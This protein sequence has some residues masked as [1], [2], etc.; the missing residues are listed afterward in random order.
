MSQANAENWSHFARQHL[1]Q[2]LNHLLAL[3]RIT[4]TVA[5]EKAVVM[6]R[7]GKVVRVW[8]YNHI[9]TTRREAP[10]LIEL[11]ANIHGHN[12]QCL[13]ILVAHFSSRIC[14]IVFHR[15][16][17]DFSHQVARVRVGPLNLRKVVHDCL[18][19]DC[20]ATCELAKHNL[21][22][23]RAL[24][25]NQFREHARVNTVQR[26]NVVLDQPLGQ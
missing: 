24:V 3:L 16:C 21:A 23:S 26:R 10:D 17:R 8:N 13:T 15:L 19:S 4:G 11:H 6:G 22:K 12:S 25:A 14:L 5:D 9:N 1:A 2:P 7:V 20:V 18:L